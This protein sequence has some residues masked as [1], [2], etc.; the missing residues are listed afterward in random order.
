MAVDKR[1]GYETGFRGMV[2]DW[3]VVDSWLH[4]RFSVK[5]LLVVLG[6]GT[7]RGMGRRRYESNHEWDG[8]QNGLLEESL[9]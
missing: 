1:Q 5:R 6:P 2:N 7:R 9:S 3:V 4:R 8:Y